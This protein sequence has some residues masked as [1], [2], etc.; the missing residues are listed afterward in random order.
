M[1]S[2]FGFLSI[3]IKEDYLNSL[4]NSG[5]SLSFVLV[6]IAELKHHAQSKER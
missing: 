2:V 1:R 4:E 3:K 5:N 6:S